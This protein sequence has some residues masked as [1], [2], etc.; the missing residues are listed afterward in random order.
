MARGRFMFDPS[1]GTVRPAHEVLAERAAE[2]VSSRSGLPSPLV[3]GTMPEVRS[4]IDGRIYDGK[5]E[6]Y[7]HVE[8]AGCAI[9]GFDKNWTD[10]VDASRIYDERKHEVDVV[11]DVKKSIEQLNSGT[12]EPINHAAA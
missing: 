2:R 6:Y 8:R 7:R 1:T 9:V 4:P 11:S 5:S 12:A 3:I 10:H